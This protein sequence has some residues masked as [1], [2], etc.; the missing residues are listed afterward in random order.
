[1]VK[2]SVQGSNRGLVWNKH[3]QIW[4]TCRFYQYKSDYSAQNEVYKHKHKHQSESNNAQDI[5]KRHGHCCQ[6]RIRPK[7]RQWFEKWLKGKSYNLEA[8]EAV[9]NTP[10]CLSQRPKKLLEHEILSFQRLTLYALNFSIVSEQPRRG[11][12]ETRRRLRAR[13]RK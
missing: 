7:R 9:K 1:M 13:D 11:N 3:M 12:P 5:S 2:C 4:P 8:F 6:C 10:E